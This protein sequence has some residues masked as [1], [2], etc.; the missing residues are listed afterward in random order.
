MNLK[1]VT[2]T[3]KVKFVMKVQMFV[4]DL[5]NVTTFIPV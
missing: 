4:G 1:L 5:V 2:L 3:F